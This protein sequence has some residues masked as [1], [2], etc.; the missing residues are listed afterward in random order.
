MVEVTLTIP[1]GPSGREA[2][3][4][5]KEDGGPEVPSG[6]ERTAPALPTAPAPAKRTMHGCAQSNPCASRLYV[7]VADRPYVRYSREEAGRF[8][9]AGARDCERTLGVDGPDTQF[10]GR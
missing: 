9:T 4:A 8:G 1:S 2:A 6:P 5:G 3:L 10:W 7:I